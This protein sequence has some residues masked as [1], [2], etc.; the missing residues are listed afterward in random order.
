MRAQTSIGES[1]I[2]NG[3]DV[4]EYENIVQAVKADHGLAKFQFRAKNLYDSGGY[5]R[6]LIKGFYGAGE[7]QGSEDRNF[8]VVADEP[9]VLLGTDRAPNPVEFLLHSLA[10]CLTSSMIYKAA[11]RGIT[12]H[13]VESTLEGDMD[14]RSFLE[15][16][17]EQR[18]GYQNIRVNFKVASDASAEEL[19]QCAEFSPVLDV[20]TR[21]TSVTLKVEKV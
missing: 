18:K 19:K 13:S 10:S 17:E 3:I 1:T 11:I 15:I 5:N 8:V 14:A 4:V 7:E 6:T 16:S 21:G 12:I 2:V 9:P 20:L